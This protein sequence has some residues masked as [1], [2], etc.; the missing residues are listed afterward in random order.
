MHYE[1]RNYRT[2]ENYFEYVNDDSGDVPEIWTT[3]CPLGGPTADALEV[4][5][6]PKKYSTR[7]QAKLVCDALSNARYTEYMKN[8][9][10]YKIL[11]RPQP[12]WMVY[13]FD[14]D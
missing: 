2:G 9:T 3:F 14:Q 11:G 13:K 1:I 6:A 5:P 7:A 12:K 10:Q 4:P 8:Y